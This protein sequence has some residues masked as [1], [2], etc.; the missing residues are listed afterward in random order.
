MAP[1]HMPAEMNFVTSPRKPTLMEDTVAWGFVCAIK[2]SFL[3]ERNVIVW[4]A[5]G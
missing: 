2:L 1:T 5:L 3:K 4:L